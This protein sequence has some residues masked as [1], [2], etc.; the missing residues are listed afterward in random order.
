MWGRDIVVILMTRLR[1]GRSVARIPVGG[2]DFSLPQN[3][4]AGFGDNLTSCSVGTGLLSQGL[5]GRD[6]KFTTSVH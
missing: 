2:R 5:S 6:A 1:A 4:D 3:T